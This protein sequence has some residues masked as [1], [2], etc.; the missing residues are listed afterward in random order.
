MLA[1]LSALRF[2][3][4]LF[5]GRLPIL[6]IK[7][8]FSFQHDFNYPGCH[9]AILSHINLDQISFKQYFIV[10]IEKHILVAVIFVKTLREDTCV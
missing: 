9:P 1:I 6:I 10:S 7:H 3:I 5:T 2:N 8:Y 4:A